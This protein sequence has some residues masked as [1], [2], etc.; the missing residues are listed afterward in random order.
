VENPDE[1]P[2]GGATG[3]FLDNINPASL[4]VLS[5]AKLEPSLAAAK[6][7][8]RYQFERVGYFYADPVDSRPGKPVFNRTATLRDS[9]AKEAGRE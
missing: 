4:E 8:D 5:V 1:P 6:P 7:G 2:A 9:W 3:T